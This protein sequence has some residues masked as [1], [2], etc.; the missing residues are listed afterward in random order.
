MAMNQTADNHATP[1][2]PH[3]AT[4]VMSVLAAIGTAPLVG[5]DAERA[6][7][8]ERLTAA[9]HAPGA[10]VLISGEAGIGKSRLASALATGP[11]RTVLSVRCDE[12][13]RDVPY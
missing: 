1:S 3:D 5:R 13:L 6:L 2:V 8:D 7:I 10:I 9:S 4:A 11:D 12:H